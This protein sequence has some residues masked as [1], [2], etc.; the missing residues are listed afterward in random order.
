M[1][2]ITF[3]ENLQARLKEFERSNTES[4]VTQTGKILSFIRELLKEL[5]QFTITYTFKDATEEILFFKHYKPVLLSQFYYVKRKFAIQLFDAFRDQKSRLANYNK[6]LKKMQSFMEMNRDFYEYCI[7][8]AQYLDRHY[9]TRTN[10]PVRAINA[11]EHFTTGFDTK[12]AKMLANEMMK[13]FVFERTTRLREEESNSP[14]PSLTWTAQ[15]IELVELVYALQAVGCFN[16]SSPDVRKIVEIFQVIFNIDLGNYYRT[17]VGLRMR[18][19]GYT[20]FLDKL[21]ENLERRIM[22][23]EQ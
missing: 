7:S 3:T 2:I 13:A 16:N 1:D 10:K 4:D 20:S 18:K 15:K 23:A 11:D 22:D 8:G 14:R 12:L 17:F 9:F 19:N 6:A 21:K 5:K